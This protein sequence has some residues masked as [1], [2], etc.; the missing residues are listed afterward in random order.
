MKA[1]QDQNVARMIKGPACLMAA[2]NDSQIV[3]QA[4]ISA[5]RFPVHIM[6]SE[7]FIGKFDRGALRYGENTGDKLHALLVNRVDLPGAGRLPRVQ[8][9]EVDNGF[10]MS[11]FYVSAQGSRTKGKGHASCQEHNQERRTMVIG[12]FHQG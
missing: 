7:I 5:D 1:A 4:G 9:G 10:T 11:R 3:S 6:R 12:R 8:R 2:A